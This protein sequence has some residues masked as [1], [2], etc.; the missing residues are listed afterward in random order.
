MGVISALTVHLYR[1]SSQ[2]NFQESAK[3]A[4][5]WMLFGAFSGRFWW[6]TAAFASA[7]LYCAVL[8]WQCYLVCVLGNVVS[9][10]L[11]E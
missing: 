10:A 7:L 6:V 11:C 4:G 8:W 5:I 3:A 9:H 2:E 1:H